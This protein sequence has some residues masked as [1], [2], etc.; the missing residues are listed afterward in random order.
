MPSELKIADRRGGGKPDA[1]LVIH[2]RLN[3]RQSNGALNAPSGIAQLRKSSE[4]VMSQSEPMNIDDYINENIGTP[5]ATALTP[6]PETVRHADD[7]RAARATASAIPIKN[8]KE[9]ARQLLV[10]QSVPVTVHHQRLPDEFG[11]LPRHHRKTSIDET[12]DRRVSWLFS[13]SPTCC[14]CLHAW[15]VAVL[16]PATHLTCIV[17]RTENDLPTS[18]HMFP[19]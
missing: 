19:R 4:Q 14:A 8:R 6:T 7:S 2:T 16:D 15:G 13:P 18:H 10:P 11:Y 9:S 5:G 1:D 17:S 3:Y 12:A